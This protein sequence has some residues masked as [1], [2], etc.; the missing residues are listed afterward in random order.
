MVDF[1]CVSPNVAEILQDSVQ[2]Q[3]LMK[4]LERHGICANVWVDGDEQPVFIQSPDIPE[5]PSYQSTESG[6]FS[7]SPRHAA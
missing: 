1:V 5:A 6:E 2:W 3:L 7:G 4:H